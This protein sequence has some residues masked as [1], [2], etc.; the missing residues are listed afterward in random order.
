MFLF[1]GKDDRKI[2]EKKLKWALIVLQ[3]NFLAAY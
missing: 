1:C 2:I 3:G